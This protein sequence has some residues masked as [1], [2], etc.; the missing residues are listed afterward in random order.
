MHRSNFNP[1]SNTKQPK[2][3]PSSL[4]T[5]GGDN[6]DGVREGRWWGWLDKNILASPLN[7]ILPMQAKYRRLLAAGCWAMNEELTEADQK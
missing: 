6:S 3:C 2:G 4:L 5:G 7:S 1:K